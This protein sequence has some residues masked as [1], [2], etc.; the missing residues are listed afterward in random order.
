MET[1]RRRLASVSRRL[2]STSFFSTSRASSISCSEVSRGTLPI[3]RR[4]M[5]TGSSTVWSI[6]T[7]RRLRNS[8]S[9]E[10]S[11][12]S[13]ASV[14]DDLH[15]HVAPAG[16]R[17]TPPR[18]ETGRRPGRERSPRPGSASPALAACSSTPW[19]TSAVSLGRRRASQARPSS[20]SRLVRL[21][22]TLCSTRSRW[23]RRRCSSRLSPPSS[24]APRS[25]ADLAAEVLLLQAQMKL[26]EHRGRD[27][28]PGRPP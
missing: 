20:G 28:A 15:A 8:S 17:G 12:S 21:A 26:L 18:R 3:S 23:K 4:Y 7:S 24:R 2:A 25:A 1:T 6:V 22:R 27:S 16:S 11:S 9:S 19:S 14:L 5:R 13:S 10:K